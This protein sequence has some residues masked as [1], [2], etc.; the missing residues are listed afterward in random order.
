MDMTPD[1]AAGAAGAAHATVLPPE[2]LVVRHTG[3]KGPRPKAPPLAG[4]ACQA[5]R[6]TQTPDAPNGSR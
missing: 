2:K 3:P 6:R 1:T 4:E 5:R